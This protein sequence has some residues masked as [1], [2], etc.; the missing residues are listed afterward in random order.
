M[1]HDTDRTVDR[2]K[3]LQG[4]TASGATVVGTGRVAARGETIGDVLFAEVGVEHDTSLEGPARRI[5]RDAPPKYRRTQGEV[6][7]YDDVLSASERGR[8]TNGRLLIAGDQIRVAP[9]MEVGRS[10]DNQA[11]TAT[12]PDLSP[13]DGVLLA[14]Q[15]DQPRPG[16]ELTPAGVAV[17]TAEGSTTVGL[18]DRQRIELSPVRVETRGFERTG[19]ATAADPEEPTEPTGYE[20]VTGEAVVTPQVVVRTHG[21]VTARL[22]ES[23]TGGA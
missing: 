1:E 10:T 12:R 22:V 8:L 23:R 5:T 17:Q 13:R 16:I 20:E 9:A 11:I 14:E 19:S 21:R 3:L 15:Y 18:D 7:F 4:M 2:R 6:V